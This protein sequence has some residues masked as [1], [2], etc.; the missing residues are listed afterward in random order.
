MPADQR[1]T[2][3]A[4]PCPKC[5][6]E[7]Q[8]T[9]VTVVG[10]HDKNLDRLFCGELNKMHCRA[11]GAEFLIQVPIVFRDDERRFLIYCLPLDE[12]G[13]AEQVEEQME[14]LTDEVFTEFNS[15]ELPDCRLTL[16]RRHFIEKIAI[17]RHRLDDRL[18]EYI[19][20]QM[21]QQGDIDSVRSELLYDFSSE[22]D[23]V[24]PFI[25]FDRETGNA[26]AGAHLPKDVYDELAEM[27]AANEELAGEIEE[28][29]PS[30]NVTV[31]KLL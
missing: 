22:A 30:Y 29:F 21:Y 27:F 17:H 13:A 7:Q 19:K 11:C 28:L 14:A 1:R 24:I 12:Q 31:D 3:T 25:V 18:I 9:A 2:R 5:G 20:Y 23:D 4:V 6:A 15:D 10:P 8:A 16:N 26:Q